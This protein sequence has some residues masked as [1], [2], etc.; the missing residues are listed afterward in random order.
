MS[1]KRGC[2][3]SRDYKS[4]KCRSKKAHESKARVVAK[5]S[6]KVSANKI[7]KA[8]LKMYSAKNKKKNSASYD[9]GGLITTRV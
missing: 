4:G 7:G 9:R 5:R 2:T 3:Y 8:M 1:G 6:R